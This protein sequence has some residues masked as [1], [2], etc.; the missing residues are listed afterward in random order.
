MHSSS[1][2]QRSM[3]VKFPTQF[4]HPSLVHHLISVERSKT[5]QFPKQISSLFFLVDQVLG[6]QTE[7]ENLWVKPRQLLVTYLLST[8]QDP[9]SVARLKLFSHSCLF[10]GGLSRRIPDQDWVRDLMGEADSSAGQ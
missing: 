9:F 2:V 8:I 6:P 4:S 5:V 1:S 3:T 10:F 7:D